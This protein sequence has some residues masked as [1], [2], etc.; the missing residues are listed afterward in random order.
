MPKKF[1]FIV[2]EGLDGSGKTTICRLLSQK[3]NCEMYKTPSS[4]FDIIRK[5]IDDYATTRS[6]F[7]FYI[8]SVVHASEEIKQILLRNHVVCDRY[9][10]STISY[11]CAMDKSILC[12]DISQLNIEMPD[13]VFYLKAPYL[14]RMGRISKREGL[15]LEQTAI[16]QSNN[17]LFQSMIEKYFKRLVNA[18][19]IDTGEMSI[20]DCVNNIYK[21]IERELCL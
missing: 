3:M 17:M 4:P 2:L 10:Y 15:S 21:I 11:H 6:R 5:H 13:I 7:F 14:E 1:Y 16:D 8:A 12:F 18:V 19:E 9:I 20:D